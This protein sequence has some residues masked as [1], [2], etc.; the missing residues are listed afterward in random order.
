MA[1]TIRIF[2]TDPDAKPKKVVR[3]DLAGQFKLGYQS[4]GKPF[5]VSEWLVI[6]EQQESAERIAELYG[7]TPEEWE[8]EGD[9]PTRVFTST[10]KVHAVIDGPDS[11]E[12]DLKLWVNGNLMHHCDGVTYLSDSPAG[13]KVG[14]RCDCPESFEERKQR[15]KAG[16]GPK[17]DI[18]VTFRLVDDLDLGRWLCRTGSWTLL[19]VLWQVEE[20]L[21]EV[22]G[23]ALVTMAIE[24][25]DNAHKTR[26]PKIV[27]K[28]SF[29]DAIAA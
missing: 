28:G 13:A 15:A 24:E 22:G 29:N 23:E 25:M 7:G 16:I 14:E 20:D 8:T 1:S 10:A 27:V 12:A 9:Y 21:E 18:R 11:V 4:K 19:R 3:P 5:T 2:D 6:T 17:P 26:Y